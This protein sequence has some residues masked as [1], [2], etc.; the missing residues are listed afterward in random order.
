MMEVS[1]PMPP[2]SVSNSALPRR[3]RAGRAMAGQEELTALSQVRS[4]ARCYHDPPWGLSIGRL[5]GLGGWVGYE[6]A[7]LSDRTLVDLLCRNIQELGHISDDL[8][9]SL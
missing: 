6:C 3:V 4:R 9:W 5:D 2:T 7:R 8:L 1:R